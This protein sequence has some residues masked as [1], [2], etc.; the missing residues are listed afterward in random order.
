[1]CEQVPI[2]ALAALDGPINTANLW[3]SEFQPMSLHSVRLKPT[4]MPKQLIATAHTIPFQ[5]HRRGLVRVS[6]H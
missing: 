1:M 6:F 3:R 5:C 4:V 2:E